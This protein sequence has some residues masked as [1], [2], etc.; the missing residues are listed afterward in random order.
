MSRNQ[1]VTECY[2]EWSSERDL[3][4]TKGHAVMSDGKQQYLPL[5]RLAWSLRQL[6]V[7]SHIARWATR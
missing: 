4:R 1:S 2:V 5:I 7:V 3:T 6:S